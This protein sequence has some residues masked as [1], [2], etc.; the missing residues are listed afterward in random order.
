MKKIQ[1]ITV[2]TLTMFL[3]LSNVS[4]YSCQ[5]S[6]DQLVREIANEYGIDIALAFAI[7]NQE[8]GWRIKIVSNKGAVGL[9]QI[10]PSTGASFCRLSEQNLYNPEKNLRCGMRYFQHQWKQFDS[11][12][13]ALCAY[14]AGPGR[15]KK[16][17]NRC[18]SFPETQNYVKNILAAMKRGVKVTKRSQKCVTPGKKLPRFRPRK[19]AQPVSPPLFA[20][21][22]TTPFSVTPRVTTEPVKS[23]PSLFQYLERSQPIASREDRQAFSESTNRVPNTGQLHHLT[24]PEESPPLFADWDTTRFYS[25]SPKVNTEPLESTPPLFETIEVKQW[26]HIGSGDN[27]FGYTYEQIQ[28]FLTQKGGDWRVPN[29]E[30]LQRIQQFQQHIYMVEDRL[31]NYLPYWTNQKTNNGYYYGYCFGHQSRCQ[32]LGTGQTQSFFAHDGLAVLL[33]RNIKTNKEEYSSFG[34]KSCIF[35]D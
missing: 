11:I 22:D 7:I 10:M 6:L 31:I 5:K 29:V 8:S 3:D 16:L 21:R 30:E 28:D 24:E 26:W 19:P 33:V 1:L 13:L 2:I 14:N 15:V 23:T 4:A 20:H 27:D 34:R 17:G 32:H 12:K 35:F 9:M 18:P 25:V